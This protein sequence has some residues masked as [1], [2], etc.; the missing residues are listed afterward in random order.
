MT[1]YIK[2]PWESRLAFHVGD[3]DLGEYVVVDKD[4]ERVASFGEL[5]KPGQEPN[6]SRSILAAA[7]PELLEMLDQ[8]VRDWPHAPDPPPGT[9]VL[10]YRKEL[11][12]ARALL[13]RVKGE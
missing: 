4:Q 8:L 11:D 7:A 9:P 6:H 13:A 10:T 1:D 3:G 12:K 5:C 2:G